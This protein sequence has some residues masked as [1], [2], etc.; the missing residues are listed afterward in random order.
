MGGT[1]PPY[2]RLGESHL[3][4]GIAMLPRRPYSSYRLPA[5][6]MHAAPADLH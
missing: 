6:L 3:P 4:G 5:N 1:A 2:H